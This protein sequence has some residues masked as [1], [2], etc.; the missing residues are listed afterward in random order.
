MVL[1]CSGDGKSSLIDRLLGRGFNEQHVV[2]NALETECKVEIKH[3]DEKWKMYES[4]QIELLDKGVTEGIKQS[5]SHDELPTGSAGKQAKHVVFDINESVEDLSEARFRL[6]TIYKHQNQSDMSIDQSILAFVLSIWDLGGQ[7]M[8]YLLHHIFLRSQCLYILV[9]NLS[10]DLHSTVPS[11]E[12]PPHARLQGMKYYESIAFWLN[13]IFSNK[14]KFGT[15]DTPPN[16]IIVG[17]HKDLLAPNDPQAQAKLVEEYFESLKEQLLDMASFKLVHCRFIAVDNKNGDE[18][19]LSILRSL[20]FDLIKEHSTKQNMRP[21]RWLRLEKRLHDLH[22]NASIPYLDKY[23]IRYDTLEEYAKQYHL[24]TEQ[25]VNTFLRY[26]HLTGDLTFSRG[27]GPGRFI[28]PHPQWLI[29][30]F[31]ALITI[32]QFYP[33]SCLQEKYQLEKQG[34]LTANKNLLSEVWQPFLKE[35]KTGEARNFL[36]GLLVE[37][38]LAIKL[39]PIRYLLP[40]MLPLRPPADESRDKTSYLYLPMLYMK[41]YSSRSSHDGICMGFEECDN[42]L[43]HGLFQKLVSKCCKQGWKW[44]GTKFQDFAMFAIDNVVISLK[45]KATW[46]SMEIDCKENYS[47]AVDCTKYLSVVFNSLKNLLETYHS[48]MWFEFCLNPCAK[49]KHECVLGLRKTSL[50]KLESM[51][52]AH[53]VYCSAHSCSFLIPEFCM[54]FTPTPCR[55][56]RQRDLMIIA[57][58][59]KNEEC[60]FSLAAELGVGNDFE[61]R[62]HENIT[63]AAFSM[64]V[65]WFNRQV[66]TLHAFTVLSNALQKA[67]LGSLVGLLLSAGGV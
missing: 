33:K 36:L 4:D 6:S 25:D 15:E 17:T 57:R 65:S 27:E 60:C 12:I 10:R 11:H 18:E 44:I 51:D 48:N 61:P 55:V 49:L 16:V 56:L 54:W 42:F 7:V 59:L 29:D 34:F 9:V 66:Y 64:L 38:D 43:P 31:R 3:C 26:H 53:A 28:V 20:V 41:F 24:N 45:V 47:V 52:K 21:V 50:M 40:C 39:D 14:D 13:M 2:T 35:D 19:N 8:Y 22:G 58:E 37:F 32:R 30:V 5:I 62:Q 46:I 63:T 1:G 23:L 67:G